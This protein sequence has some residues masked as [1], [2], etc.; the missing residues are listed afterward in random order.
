M[1]LLVNGA[2]AI[3]G[4]GVIRVRT[5]CNDQQIW[6]EV[7]DTGV[8]IPPENIN[9]IFDPFFTTKAL[10]KGTGLGLSLAWGIVQRHR[11]TIEVKSEPGKGST[12]RVLLP[13]D[14]Q[15]ETLSPK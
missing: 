5:G 14:G 7:T 13:I 11:G 8:G 2:H 9:R 6:V 1:N 10:G 4:Q 12:F 3:E 15:V